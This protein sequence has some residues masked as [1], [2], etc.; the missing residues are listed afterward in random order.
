[1]I[2]KAEVTRMEKFPLKQWGKLNEITDAAEEEKFLEKFIHQPALW[3]FMTETAVPDLTKL[4]QTNFSNDDDFA[5]LYSCTK[6]VIDLLDKKVNKV[7][8]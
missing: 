1:M 6:M 4:N 5:I 2:N 3:N 7:T 8:K